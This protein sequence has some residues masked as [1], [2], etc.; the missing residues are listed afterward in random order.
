MQQLLDQIDTAHTGQLAKSQIAAS[1]IDWQA[2][3]QRNAD[4]WL[5]SVHKVF[6]SFDTDADGVIAPDQIVD[7]LRTKLPS[8]EVCWSIFSKDYYSAFCVWPFQH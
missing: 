1:Q 5:A 4:Q 2:V 6:K 3:Q 8:S 7:C